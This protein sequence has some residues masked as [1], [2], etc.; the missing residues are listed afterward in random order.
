[1]RL[2]SEAPVDVLTLTR[3]EITIR[4][5]GV[6]KNAI[7]ACGGRVNEFRAPGAVTLLLSGGLD[8]AACLHYY[9][10][11]GYEVSPLFVSYQ[12]PAGGRERRA[13]FEIAHHYDLELSEVNCE[14]IAVPP[15]GLIIGRNGFLIFAAAMWSQGR[16]ALI[17]IGLHAGTSYVDSSEAFLIGIDQLINDSTQNTQRVDAPFIRWS[18][19]QVRRYAVDSGVPV[20]LT[21]S[22]ETSEHPCGSCAS[23]QDRALLDVAS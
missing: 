2:S 13:A 20:G 15:S 16:S 21:Y 14:P 3:H 1:M 10:H 5:S 9:R 17:G 18:K 6:P 11:L 22:C 12:Q 7:N 23:C 8:S 19:S 4:D